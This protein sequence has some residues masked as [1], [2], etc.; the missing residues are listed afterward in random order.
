VDRQGSA[1]RHRVTG[2]HGEV[3]EDLLEP[4]W[5]DENGSQVRCKLAAEL[6]VL[7]KRAFEQLLD[8]DNHGVDVYDLRLDDLAAREREELVCEVGGSLG[9]EA[10]LLDIGA[11][12][13]PRLLVVGGCRR[14][15]ALRDE[16]RVVDDHGE[17]V[18]EV[19]GD[20]TG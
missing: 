1:V 2:V 4:S 19:V 5:I 10:D 11:H 13:V 14:V 18:V 6:D 20:A 12:G 7:P 8:I 15:E 9:G 17:Q 3:D 16:R